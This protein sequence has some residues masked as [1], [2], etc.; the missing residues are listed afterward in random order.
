[1]LNLFLSLSRSSPPC[2]PGPRG[3]GT[4]DPL[5]AATRPATLRREG[6]VGA[7][8][9][10]GERGRAAGPSARKR[11]SEPGGSAGRSAGAAAGAAQLHLPPADL[12]ARPAPGAGPPRVSVPFAGHRVLFQEWDRAAGNAGMGGT[13]RGLRGAPQIRRWRRA[14]PGAGFLFRALPPG[15]GPTGLGERPAASTPAL[16]CPPPP[17]GGDPRP[18]PPGSGGPASSLC[19]PRP[20]PAAAGAGAFAPRRRDSSVRSG[21]LPS[22][23]CNSN[24]TVRERDPSARRPRSAPAADPRSWRPRR[25]TAVGIGGPGSV[26]RLVWRVPALQIFPR[27]GGGGGDVQGGLESKPVASPSRRSM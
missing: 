19:A 21:L 18:P 12:R 14:D 20:P 17:G 16:R 2:S 8:P 7:R 3:G 10:S 11:K 13:G 24:G 1:M 15:W 26:A 27:A 4:Q 9:A 5:L 22:Q 25:R 23:P 6:R